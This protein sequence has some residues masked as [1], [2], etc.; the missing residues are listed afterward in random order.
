MKH[1]PESTLQNYFGDKLTLYFAFLNFYRDRLLVISILG[2]LMMIPVMIYMVIS[3]SFTIEDENNSKFIKV[4]Y[5]LQICFSVLIV[6]WIKSFQWKWKDFERGF[7][8]RYGKNEG[9]STS[10]EDV[11]PGFV[12][13]WKRNL[14]DDKVNDIAEDGLKKKRKLFA[15]FLVIMT[16]IALAGISTYFILFFK[17]KSYEFGLLSDP[18]GRNSVNI[19][20]SQT[21]KIDLNNSTGDRKSVV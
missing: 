18:F 10:A 21:T 9:V 3:P 19:T 11:R 13:I 7:S 6:L 17:R 15:L 1:Y 12:G 4:Y 8:I 16:L 20:T 5:S 2:L 14:I